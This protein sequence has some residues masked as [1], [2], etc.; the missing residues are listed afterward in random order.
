MKLTLDA[1]TEEEFKK[2]FFSKKEIKVLKNGQEIYFR[3]SNKVRNEFRYNEIKQSLNI[4]TYHLTNI[5]PNSKR[6]YK[7]RRKIYNSTLGYIGKDTL[8]RGGFRYDYGKNIYLGNSVFVNHECLF[9]DAER[10]F[11]GDNVSFG[12]RVCLYTIGHFYTPN[13]NI[14]N[15]RE[16]EPIYIDKNVWIGGNSILLSGVYIGKNSIIAAG[17]LVKNNVPSNVIVAGRPAKIIKQL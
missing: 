17:S 11:I 9:L 16:R 10:I 6:G 2:I 4:L 13:S 3:E 12:P 5:L 8:I 15:N 14:Q 7:L 1:K